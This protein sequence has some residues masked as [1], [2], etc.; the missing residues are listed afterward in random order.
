MNI[1][2][3]AVEVPGPI[4]SDTDNTDEL[5]TQ[6]HPAL[7]RLR[8]WPYPDQISHH[9]Y[10]AYMKQSHDV[11]G[12]SD[13]PG[14]FEEKE[15]KLWELNTFVDCEVLG[16]RGIWTSEE[17]RRIGNVDIGRTMYF[18][19]PYYGRRLWAIVRILM[20]KQYV[21]LGELVERVHAV[22]ERAAGR[23]T[24]SPL[25]AEPAS[26][27]NEKIVLRNKHHKEAVGKGDPQS[28]KGMAGSVLCR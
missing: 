9:L 20:E 23:T 28:F 7:H 3:K 11:G 10:R 15:E 13:A 21:T 26:T 4:R 18:G 19:L 22:Q 2:K 5:V 17:R 24:Q 25:E 1:I 6:I 8:D 16:W 14:I 27:G 12:E